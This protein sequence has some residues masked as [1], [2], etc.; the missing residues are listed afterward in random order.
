MCFKILKD[1]EKKK[2]ALEKSSFLLASH[3]LRQPMLL[4]LSYLFG[5]ILN[6]YNKYFSLQLPLSFFFTQT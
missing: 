1:L 2:L 5:E 6:I 4:F 3:A